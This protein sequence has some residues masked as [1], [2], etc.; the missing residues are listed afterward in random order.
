MIIMMI[1]III[2]NVSLNFGP[3]IRYSESQPKKK[4]TKK[5]KKNTCR[6]VDF[7]VQEDHK[8]KLKEREKRDKY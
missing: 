4:Q 2:T 1:T 6:I 5:Q 3:T 8:I 7:A